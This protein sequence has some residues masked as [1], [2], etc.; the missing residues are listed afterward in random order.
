MNFGSPCFATQNDDQFYNSLVTLTT[1]GKQFQRWENILANCFCFDP[2][3]QFV[4][5]D[6][7]DRYAECEYLVSWN[8]RNQNFRL[9]L[10]VVTTQP[11]TSPVF[12][13]TQPYRMC[14]ALRSRL[15][16]TVRLDFLWVRRFI[17]I[18]NDHYNNQF[19]TYWIGLQ[20]NDGIWSWDS[21]ASYGG[22][23]NWGPNQPN[24]GFQC[25][26]VYKGSDS[27]FHWQTEQCSYQ[28]PLHVYFCQKYACDVD[29][30]CA[31]PWSVN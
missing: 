9:T 15:S 30:Y 24:T 2:Y 5:I 6:G 21:G 16:W 4:D 29:N 27:N 17:E 19:Q 10:Q 22:Y 28:D 26:T 18:N 25:V 13:R 7:C 3:N 14:W 1:Q 8:A 12:R 20:S 31:T 11:E 23:T